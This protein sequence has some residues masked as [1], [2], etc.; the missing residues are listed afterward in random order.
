MRFELIG[1]SNL[2]NKIKGNASR[3]LALGNLPLLHWLLS[4]LLDTPV[5]VS[6]SHPTPSQTI[7]GYL[8]GQGFANVFEHLSPTYQPFGFNR[9]KSKLEYTLNYPLRLV[10][11]SDGVG[12][13]VVIR[14]VEFMI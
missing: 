2:N 11:T 7:A 14:S 4:E 8:T 5:S 6:L 1:S 3:E 10:F 13:R 9:I 12:I